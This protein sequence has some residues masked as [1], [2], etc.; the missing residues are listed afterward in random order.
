MKRPVDRFIYC[1]LDFKTTA[2]KNKL[3]TCLSIYL[4]LKYFF[5]VSIVKFPCSSLVLKAISELLEHFEKQKEL[6][7]TTFDHL[8]L[9]RSFSS[10]PKYFFFIFPSHQIGLRDETFELKVLSNLKELSFRNMP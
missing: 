9:F 3:C 7:F 2:S 6:C 10:P 4:L 1:F 8:A 5:L